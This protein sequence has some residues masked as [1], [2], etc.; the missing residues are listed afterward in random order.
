MLNIWIECFQAHISLFV[1]LR[2]IQETS[3]G[4]DRI[5]TPDTQYIRTCASIRTKYV[6]TFSYMYSPSNFTSLRTPRTKS[7]KYRQHEED[8]AQASR[9]IR[10]CACL[11][12]CVR[13][14]VC[15]GS[16]GRPERARER[17][18]PQ[19]FPGVEQSVW[20]LLA[21]PSRWKLKGTSSGRFTTRG[22]WDESL[23]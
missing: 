4:I 16:A 21:I 5:R 19:R 10:L 15:V 8:A 18:L 14:C 22:F 7:A 13:V 20:R 11:R 1:D 6:L 12:S 17:V 9:R 2:H 23:T 3:S